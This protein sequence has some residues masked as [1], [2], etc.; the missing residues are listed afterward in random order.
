M[1]KKKYDSFIT[2]ALISTAVMLLLGMLLVV[3]PEVLVDNFSYFVGIILVI[4][5]FGLVFKKSRF[6]FIDYISLG[7]LLVILGTI[8]LIYPEMLVTL[9]PIILGIWLILNSIF[10]IRMSLLLKNLGNSSWIFTIIFATITIICGILMILNPTDGALFLTTFLGVDLIVYALFD[11]SN[12]MIFRSYVDD[13]VK[14]LKKEE[15]LL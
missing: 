5:G 3:F 10:R 9:I 12:L 2:I 4:G 8:I 11:L 13:I 6:L 7:I 15:K 1:I 14:Q